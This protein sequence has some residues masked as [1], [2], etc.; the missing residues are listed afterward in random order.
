MENRHVSMI[1]SRRNLAFLLI[2]LGVV[3]R[4]LYASM[5]VDVSDAYLNL[6]TAKSMRDC[7]CIP[8]VDTWG[9]SNLFR[10]P[11]GAIWMAVMMPYPIIAVV[12]AGL[13][14]VFLTY[15]IA[16]KIGL[17]DDYSLL[18]AGIVSV[19]PEAIAFSST[20][21]MDIF[22]GVYLAL[23][24]YFLM[25]GHAGI[26]GAFSALGS[27]AKTDGLVFFPAPAIYLAW[28]R[29]WK[30]LLVYTLV[31][32]LLAIPWL[33]HMWTVFGNPFYPYFGT[34]FGDTSTPAVGHQVPLYHY[35]LGL[36]LTLFGVPEGSHWTALEIAASHGI[37]S[38]VIWA[39]YLAAIIATIA[40]LYGSWRSSLKMNADTRA[41]IY[42]AFL[43][44]GMFFLA[45]T[46]LPIGSDVLDLRYA[47]VLIPIFGIG[48]ISLDKRWLTFVV[49]L[50]LIG[51]VGLFARFYIAEAAIAPFHEGIEQVKKLPTDA[52]V[53]SDADTTIYSY[54]ISY[55]TGRV[56][57]PYLD[58]SY[59]RG[60][61]IPFLWSRYQEIRDRGPNYLWTTNMSLVCGSDPMFKNERIKICAMN[62]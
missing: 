41:I 25:S 38:I 15:L 35:L 9:T 1:L 44:Y 18:A 55:E 20:N 10:P 53:L 12:I 58:N 51:S 27:L 57:F 29:R 19:I 31:F 30:D 42:C 33:I 60:T 40:I 24:I 7:H 61:N 26:S 28:K 49:I 6:A 16:K 8:T 17:T 36:P 56:G 32:L 4:I 62:R 39:G 43:M 50:L 22:T 21:S 45:R 52:V 13:A 48:T 2:F 14:L 59:N 3:L 47:I 5:S 34:L 54:G 11:A 37:P 46:I 23:S